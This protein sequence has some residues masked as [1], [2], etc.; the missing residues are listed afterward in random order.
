MVISQIIGGLG[1]QMF[2]YAAA[3]TLSLKKGQALRLDVA[4]FSGYG[5]H[6][7]FELQRVFNI[8]AEIATE[9]EV[10]NILGWLIAPGIRRILARPGMAALRR[11]GFVV[12]PHFHYWPDISKVPQDSYL[13]GYWQ[14][15]KYFLDVAPVIR[16][17]FTFRHPLVSLNVG[18]AEQIGTVNA[19]SLHVRRGD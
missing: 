12:E 14:S 6:Q 13:S 2:Q 9:A 11:S 19:V 17:D 5:L 18:L 10:R 16:V 3:R 8:P 15:E 7:G 1:N 4:G